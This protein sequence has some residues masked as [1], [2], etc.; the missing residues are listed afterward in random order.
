MNDYDA[1]ILALT[2]DIQGLSRKYC[3]PIDNVLWDIKTLNLKGEINHAKQARISEY[4][5]CR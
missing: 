4:I 5:E 1:S 3:R 2:R